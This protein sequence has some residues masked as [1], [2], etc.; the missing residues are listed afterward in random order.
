MASIS[1][2]SLTGDDQLLKN[3]DDDDDD[4][5]FRSAVVT[6]LQ[7]ETGETIE[8]TRL[9]PA[10]YF[11]EISLLLDQPRAATVRAL[12]ETKCVKLDR[13]R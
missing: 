11:G 2:S 9:G 6:Q 5:F 7:P 13:A 4:L 10:E 1:S 3:Y 8:L 12:Q